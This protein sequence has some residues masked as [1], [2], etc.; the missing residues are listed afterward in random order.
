MIW[1][2]LN[3]F[4]NIK[5]FK[6]FSEAARRGELSQ[7]TWSRDITELENIFGTRLISRDYKGIKLTDKG[8]NLL[9][10]IQT[11]KTNLNN[12]KSTD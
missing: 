12:F 10:I 7:S 9:E 11:F 3:R 1:E 8:R 5:K 6:S 4:T 2:K